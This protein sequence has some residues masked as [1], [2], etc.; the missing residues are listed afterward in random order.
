MLMLGI[1]K[2][3]RPFHPPR[4][5]PRLPVART[6]GGAG[7]VGTVTTVETDGSGDLVSAGCG[8]GLLQQEGV[9]V[10]RDSHN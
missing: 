9:G 2:S 3:A 5:G 4:P 7:Q 8:C 10:S 6:A 1:A